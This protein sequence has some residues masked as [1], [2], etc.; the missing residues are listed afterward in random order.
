[1]LKLIQSIILF[2][3]KLL[4]REIQPSQTLIDTKLVCISASYPE[5]AANMKVPAKLMEN[6]GR[7]YVQ[8]YLKIREIYP[9]IK[10]LSWYRNPELNAKVGGVR[11]SDHT[12]GAAFD[13]WVPGVDIADVF[14]DDRLRALSF[15]EMIIY[16]KQKFIHISINHI[17]KPFKKE[18]RINDGKGKGSRALPA[19]YRFDS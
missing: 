7:L 13:F 10:I 8:I 3:K 9:D 11:I 6:V 18:L 2:I 12:F 5:I 14:N 16:P 17:K 4:E 19:T 1:M 15:R